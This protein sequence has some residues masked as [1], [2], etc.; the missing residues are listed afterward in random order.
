MARGMHACSPGPQ[1]VCLLHG[2]LELPSRVHPQ[3]LQ[4][5]VETLHLFGHTMQQRLPTKCGKVTTH[6]HPSEALDRMVTSGARDG[7][8]NCAQLRS[9][10]T[11]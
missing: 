6:K 11:T 1:L 2:Y 7:T 9:I 4:E 10:A 5:P 3:A 8:V